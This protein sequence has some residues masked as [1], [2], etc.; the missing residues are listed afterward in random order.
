[1]IS[2]I[3]PVMQPFDLDHCTYDDIGIIVGSATITQ[4]HCT[5]NEIGPY[6][7]SHD[8]IG[9]PLQLLTWSMHIPISF[10]VNSALM[11]DIH[12][13]FD[14]NDFLY[15]YMICN[16]CLIQQFIDTCDSSKRV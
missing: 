8:D 5:C 10:V 1:M 15:K 14:R 3:S 2:S 6:R 16:R 13:N 9:H 7:P 4:Y 12:P 11:V